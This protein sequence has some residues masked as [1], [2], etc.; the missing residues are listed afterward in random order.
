MGVLMARLRV[1]QKRRS[2]GL[3]VRR[4]GSSSGTTG[5]LTVDFRGV[6]ERPVELYTE[7]GRGLKLRAAVPVGI[8]KR[9]RI[10][11]ISALLDAAG[12]VA[13]E[14]GMKRLAVEVIGDDSQREAVEAVIAK[15]AIRIIEIKVKNPS[16][17]RGE[18]SLRTPKRE[19]VKLKT[20][21]ARRMAMSVWGTS[22]AGVWLESPNSY[23][24][25]T[26][27]LDVY[28]A[29]RLTDFENALEA[30]K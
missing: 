28:L 16:D 20:E 3:R 7:S 26:R 15:W 8:S 5:R 23:L 22:A 13:Q 29:G 1:P 18:K 14:T 4:T 10:R 6:G 21:E 17:P 25:G 24:G 9:L 19:T 30:E 12:V 11:R 27:P 2:V